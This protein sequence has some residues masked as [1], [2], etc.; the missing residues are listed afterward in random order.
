MSLRLCVLGSGSTG[1]C[2]YAAGESSALLIDLGLPAMRVEKCLRTLGADPDGVSVI[3]THCHSDHISGVETFCRRHPRAGLYC[4]DFCADSLRFKLGE[5][6]ERLAVEDGD[7]FV[8]ELTVSPFRVS[9]DVPCVGY[10]ILCGGRKVSVVTDIGFMPDETLERL[11]DSDL[12][13]IECNHDESL[14]K[15]NAHYS[16]QLKRRILSPQGHL[17][18]A[19]CARSV[20]YLASRGVGQF[21][22]AHLSR[23]NNYPELA[24][25][26]CRDA[27]AQMGFTEGKDVMLEIAAPDKMSGLFEIGDRG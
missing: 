27:L 8:G 18:N 7:F 9:H 5:A 14:L 17:S 10:C 12:V 24:F 3:L 2:I 23:E 13:V 6:R 26:T 1:N 19:D 4:S 15:G 21:V 25:R 22:L 11:A 20:A 16:Y